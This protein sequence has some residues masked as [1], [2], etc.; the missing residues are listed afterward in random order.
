MP[1]PCGCRRAWRNLV[2]TYDLDAALLRYEDR[3]R[4]VLGPA[5]P[6]DRPTVEFH[7]TSALLFPPKDWA[8][9]HWDDV[10]MLFLRRTE[11]RAE[12]LGDSEYRFVQPED[13]QATLRRASVDD[14]FRAGL[15]DDLQRKLAE[16]PDSRRARVILEALQP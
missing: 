12:A 16:H 11:A 15:I 2:E 8:L 7:T 4:Q 6:G 1:R 14:A 10:S 3:P 9:V 13:T 5:T